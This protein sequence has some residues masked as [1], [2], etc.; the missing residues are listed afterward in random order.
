MYSAQSGK[1]KVELA[2]GGAWTQEEC[3]GCSERERLLPTMVN[4]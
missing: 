1:K 3:C 2:A 4:L